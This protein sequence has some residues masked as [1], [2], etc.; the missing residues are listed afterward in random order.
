MGT[1][2]QQNKYTHIYACDISKQVIVEIYFL[3]RKKNELF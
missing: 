1:E 2:T 3:S